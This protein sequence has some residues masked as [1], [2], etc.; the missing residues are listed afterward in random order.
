MK[1]FELAKHSYRWNCTF[2]KCWRTLVMYSTFQ[3]QS[4][5]YA[6]AVQRATIFLWMQPIYTAF[7]QG[8][9]HRES[10]TLPVISGCE[11]EWERSQESSQRGLMV[12]TEE[13][14]EKLMEKLKMLQGR[15]LFFPST[16]RVKLY[17][18]QYSFSDRVHIP[19]LGFQIS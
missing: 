3:K 6:P 9:C 2:F 19:H 10:Q 11:Q 15:H 8:E 17:K 13:N 18:K 4:S 1:P 16:S 5:V 14:R 12:L 7:Q